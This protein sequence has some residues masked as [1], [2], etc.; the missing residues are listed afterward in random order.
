M[1]ISC[2][3]AWFDGEHDVLPPPSLPAIDCNVCNIE[4][5]REPVK[6]IIA[7]DAAASRLTKPRAAAF[8]RSL[9]RRLFRTT[10]ALA[11]FVL[12]HAHAFSC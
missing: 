12:L 9:A 10:T 7:D 11:E 1:P 8:W 3:C 5:D 2:A 6:R 4:L